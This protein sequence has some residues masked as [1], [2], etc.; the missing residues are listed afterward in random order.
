MIAAIVNTPTPVVTISNRHLQVDVVPLLGGRALRIIHRQTGKCVT[1]VNTTRNLMFPFCGGEESCVANIFN[2]HQ[3]GQMDPALPIKK[4]DSSVTLKI[5]TTN[6]FKL[7]RTLALATDRPVLTVTAGVTNPGNKP[8]E[9]QLRS[10]L[11]LRL[12]EVGRTRVKFT[13]RGGTQIDKDT[14]DVIAGLREGEHFYDQDC[15]SG[16]WTFTGTEGMQVTQRFDDHNV[17]FT[18]LIAYPEDLNDLDVQL[19]AKRQMLGPGETATLAH[20][21][22]VR[23]TQQPE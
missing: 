11:G 6:G 1:G 21:L 17:D 8:R 4:T 15:P 20:E 23:P 14:T 10:H 3:G 2:M 9:A 22:E 5:T 7:T 12:G 18:W 16:S 13:S 19:W